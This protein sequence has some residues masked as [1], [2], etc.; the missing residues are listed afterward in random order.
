VKRRLLSVILVLTILMGVFPVTA[1]A[2]NYHGVEFS[3]FDS[4][5][6]EGGIFDAQVRVVGL[7]NENTTYRWQTD[8]SFGQKGHWSDLKDNSAWRGTKTDH[9]QLYTNSG[10]LYGTGWED[11]PF[12]CL[13]TVNGKEY[14]SPNF[15][16]Q[17]MPAGLL[18]KCLAEDNEGFKE[19]IG[20]GMSGHERVL[21]KSDEGFPTHATAYAGEQLGF[22]I[23]CTDPSEVFF[24][25]FYRSEVSFVPEIKVYKNG[26]LVQSGEDQCLYTP[27]TAGDTLTVEHILRVKAGETDHGVY[28]SNKMTIDIIAPEPVSTA[29]A[30]Y[31]CSLLKERYNESQ[32]LISVSKGS[33]LQIIENSGDTWYKVLY[34]NTVGWLPADALNIQNRIAP[35]NTFDTVE[36]SIIWPSADLPAPFTAKTG[37]SGYT[38]HSIDWW[39][40]DEERFLE[41]GEVFKDDCIYGVTIWLTAEGGSEFAVNDNNVPIVKGLI[42]G[43]SVDVHKAYEQDPRQVIELSADFAPMLHKCAPVL[44]QR[45]QPTCQQVGHEGYYLCECGKAYGDAEASKLI[46][47]EQDG[48]LPIAAHKMGSWS[49]NGTHHYRKCKICAAIIPGSNAAHSGNPCNVCGFMGHV[50]QLEPVHMI[51]PTCE[52]DGFEKYYK[53][54]CGKTYKDSAGKQPVD[55]NTWGVIPKLPHSPGEW[56]YNSTDH[57]S[58]CAYCNKTIPGTTK[59]HSGDPCG[60]CGF[61]SHVCQLKPVRMVDPTC[62]RDGFEK[63]Y[64]CD[65]GKAYKDSAGK[66]P[67][68]LNT[69]GVIPK[70]PHSPGE[71]TYNSTDHASLCAYCN[72]TIP[73]TTQAH[74]GDVCSVCGYVDLR[75]LASAKKVISMVDIGDVALP[76]V[77]SAPDYTVSVGS[78]YKV[79]QDSQ[80]YQWM[81]RGIAW[82]DITDGKFVS[83]RHTFMDGHQYQ[84][85]ISL[86][87]TGSNVFEYPNATVNGNYAES[88]GDKYSLTVCYTFQPCTAR[89]TAGTRPFRD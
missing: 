14:A 62:E 54:D 10:V 42:N 18:I 40:H 15:Y 26:R 39:D 46:D 48:V 3:L 16:I 58:L 49:Y 77:G 6:Y 7:N 70:L 4:F 25:N 36:V 35:S 8:T 86:C 74:S 65:C 89:N 13:V 24:S 73:G 38:V 75:G 87:P 43:S 12:R 71:W 1:L 20:V 23:N 41:Q 11:I 69:W 59:A 53:C 19:S 17:V 80:A 31:D 55:L 67:V 9:L 56:T 78:G 29:A 68:D 44:I 82:Y 50:C 37:N 83:F 28:Q 33:E 76:K 88:F 63:Y 21:S 45:I 85:Y 27:T 5:V 32:K 2:D 57:A 64:K 51:D 84:V 47:P 66:Q 60:V 30:K 81:H 72:K 79:N 61:T 52:H 34:D 22:T